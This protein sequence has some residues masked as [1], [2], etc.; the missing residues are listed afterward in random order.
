MIKRLCIDL[1]VLVVVFC[2]ACVVGLLTNISL[3][4]P[5]SFT[6]RNR[7]ERMQDSIQRI[8]GEETANLPGSI[9]KKV[10][11]A[12][13]VEYV[14]NRKCVIFDARPEIFFRLGHVPGA[15]SL[16]REDFELQYQVH[17]EK[18]EIDRTQP[19]VV[20]CS[21][22][23]CEDAGLVEKALS[24]LGYGNVGVFEGGWNAWKQNGRMAEKAE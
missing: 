16:P 13:F 11:F 15:L 19:I 18:L 4:R 2:C 23:T 3:G 5:M 8:A 20:Y 6:Y 22:E 12:E 1:R 7:A 24:S 14:E 9:P 21:S 10:S 17:R